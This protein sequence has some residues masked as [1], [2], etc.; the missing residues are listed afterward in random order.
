MVVVVIREDFLI[1][2]FSE[3]GLTE[4]SSDARDFLAGPVGSGWAR[5]EEGGAGSRSI[6]CQA[7]TGL[8]F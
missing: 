7:V 8:D 4:G 3:N 2:D 5:W 6:L 1:R